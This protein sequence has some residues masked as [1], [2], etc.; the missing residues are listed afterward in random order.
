MTAQR[1]YTDTCFAQVTAPGL[2]GGFSFR[3]LNKLKGGNSWIHSTAQRK[4]HS[5]TEFGKKNSEN[6]FGES[7]TF[8]EQMKSCNQRQSAI[9]PSAQEW[10]DRTV[11]EHAC[12]KM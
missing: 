12:S 10:S 3:G 2:F 7:E 8:T 5:K 11:A 6:E 4:E 9:S 1:S